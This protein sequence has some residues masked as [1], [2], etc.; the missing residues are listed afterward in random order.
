MENEYKYKVGDIVDWCEDGLANYRI[1]E[2]WHYDGFPKLGNKVRLKCL[3]D[4][5]EIQ[6]FERFIKLTPAGQV[7][8]G[9]G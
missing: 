2:M 6:T 8:Y 9:R 3:E 7:L 1:L 4:G 5:V